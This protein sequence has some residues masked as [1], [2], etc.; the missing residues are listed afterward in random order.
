MTAINGSL[1]WHS[2][3][4]KS[5]IPEFQKQSS[6]QYWGWPRY[7]CLTPG[8]SDTSLIVRISHCH[9]SWCHWSAVWKSFHIVN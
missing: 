2:M 5:P 4:A 8:K 9:T 7:A 1:N 3:I 6:P